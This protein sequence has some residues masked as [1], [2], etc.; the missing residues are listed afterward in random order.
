MSYLRSTSTWLAHHRLCCEETFLPRAD[1]LIQKAT[2]VILTIFYD[3]S[4]IPSFRK[5]ILTNSLGSFFFF[6]VFYLL[7]TT[8]KVKN[9]HPHFVAVG[10][11]GL[12]SQK[13]LPRAVELMTIHCPTQLRAIIC[14]FSF[15]TLLSMRWVHLHWIASLQSVIR[16]NSTTEQWADNTWAITAKLFRFFRALSSLCGVH[17]A[18]NSNLHSW[19]Q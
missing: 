9:V 14:A 5:L 19:T 6:F 11:L 1:F 18:T 8:P 17:Q 3:V 7:S 12:G 4:P 2:L 13:C 15:M 16:L 10:V